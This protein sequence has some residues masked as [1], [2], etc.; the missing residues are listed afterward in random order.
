MIFRSITAAALPLLLVTSL[1][2][3]SSASVNINEADA[4]ALQALVGVGPATAAAI[5]QDR[6]DNGP[7]ESA[8]ALTRVNGI[9][10]VTLDTI[11]EQITLE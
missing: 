1:A 9:G 7:Y 6:A 3:A 4:E 5:I 11:R 8:E 2:S 10:V